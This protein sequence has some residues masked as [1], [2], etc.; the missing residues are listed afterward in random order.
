MKKL[1]L[2]AILCANLS[3]VYAQ[4]T[5]LEQRCRIDYTNWS[6]SYAEEFNNPS[7]SNGSGLKSTDYLQYQGGTYSPSSSANWEFGYPWAQPGVAGSPITYNN[8]GNSWESE[9][10][11]SDEANIKVENG[12]LKL[13]AIKLATPQT[14]YL[15]NGTPKTVKYTSGMLHWNMPVDQ[16]ADGTSA[17]VPG[18]L[19]GMYEVRA[20]MP[21]GTGCFPAFWLWGNGSEIDIFEYMDRNDVSD[22]T[23]CAITYPLECP[24]K[25]QN[26]VI[27]SFATGSQP[28]SCG[29]IAYTRNHNG[30]LSTHPS[31]H[32]VD[33]SDD[34]HTYSCVWTPEKVTFFFDDEAVRTVTIQPWAQSGITSPTYA[35]PMSLI[36]NLAVAEWW[37]WDTADFGTSATMEVDYIRVYR[38]NNT[39]LPSNPTLQQYTTYYNAANYMTSQCINGHDG[40]LGNTYGNNF[41]PSGPMLATANNLWFRGT[42]GRLWNYWKNWST[43]KW[44]GPVPFNWGTTDLSPNTNFIIDQTNGYLYYV[45]NSNQLKGFN[46]ATPNIASVLA[47]TAT[48]VA[49]DLAI[50]PGDWKIYYRTT[51]GQIS[52]TWRTGSGISSWAYPASLPTIPSSKTVSEG[53]TQVAGS[54]RL[55]FKTTDHQLW[56]TEWSGS[57][58]VYSQVTAYNSATQTTGAVTGVDGGII[59]KS[60]GQIFFRG[61]GGLI[62]NIWND[63]TQSVLTPLD[64]NPTALAHTKYQNNITGS[65]KMMSMNSAGTIYY[66]AVDQKIW[67]YYYSNGFWYNK[68][69]TGE[70][71][72]QFPELALNHFALNPAGELFH[73]MYFPENFK[74]TLMNYYIAA[75]DILNPVCGSNPNYYRPLGQETTTLDAI[76]D[77]QD[78][79][80]VTNSVSSLIQEN[81]VQAFPS[82][83]ND[84]LNIEIGLKATAQVEVNLYNI[85]GQLV[86]NLVPLQT[87]SE[88]IEIH[89][90]DLSFLDAGMYY[91]QVRIDGKVYS[92]KVVKI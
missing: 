54:S 57:A 24:N 2:L 75:C 10:Y 71:V 33:L 16:A 30:A 80:Q 62:W 21:K 89:D 59:V 34:F 46:L 35:R 27:N 92:D 18:F 84:K 53:F 67:Y 69:L 61:T 1:F 43:N 64:W 91:Y 58:W 38:P 73:A 9:L 11:T 52:N 51:S 60:N 63:G 3:F 82:P 22:A 77:K 78:N 20:K 49:G 39:T 55:Y 19:Y 13:T 56:Y 79:Q 90:F 17:W 65:T 70:D 7:P 12:M 14:Y 68:P 45:S 31:I 28:S 37:N 29:Q 25:M 76:E 42:D 47:T 15:P 66:K 88:G 36:I 72:N 23:Q 87:K 6:I 86:K 40:Y 50:I 48:N 32:G 85:S 5:N 74:N 4:S 81:M 8:I 83:F 26:N 41:E 44:D